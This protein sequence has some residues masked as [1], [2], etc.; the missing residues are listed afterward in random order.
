MKR[1]KLYG[2]YKRVLHIDF[3]KSLEPLYDYVLP[4]SQTMQELDM[5]AIADESNNKLMSNVH[6]QWSLTLEKLQ[7][8]ASFEHWIQSRGHARAM[9]DINVWRD[10]VNGNRAASTPWWCW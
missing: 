6:Y 10:R 8:L 4:I 7:S 1:K 9:A 3:N 2:N 5:L